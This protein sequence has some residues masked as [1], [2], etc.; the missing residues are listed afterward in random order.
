M[1]A[2]VVFLIGVNV[3]P[4]HKENLKCDPAQQNKIR[5]DIYPFFVKCNLKGL[6]LRM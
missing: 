6:V 1:K 5:C 2:H 4:V 3:H